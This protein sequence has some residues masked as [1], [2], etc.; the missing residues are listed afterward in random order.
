VSP[1]DGRA[2]AERV[3][4]EFDADRDA[5]SVMENL[6][7]IVRAARVSTTAAEREV[8][9]SMAQLFV[10]RQLALEPGQS[11]KEL[12]ARARTTQSSVSEV[13]ARLVK[14]GF[15]ARR[16]ATSDR[17]RAE[18]TITARGRALLARAPETIQER[19]L[20]GLRRLDDAER[21]TLARGM[22]AWLR[23]SG[24]EDVPATMLFE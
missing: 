13:A 17:R 9:V 21:H 23:A 10:L 2:N 22:E 4:I 19:L 18:L 7:R 3:E 14:R 8:G 15:V 5:M 16:A 11:L 24:L 1:G 20:E 12:A 6:R